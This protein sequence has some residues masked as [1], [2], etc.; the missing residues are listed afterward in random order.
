MTEGIM[1]LGEEIEARNL[2]RC[3]VKGIGAIL[4]GTSILG[5]AILGTHEY[6]EHAGDLAAAEA[7][8]RT[9][10]VQEENTRLGSVLFYT[11]WPGRQIGYWYAELRQ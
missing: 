9:I 7:H 3:A 1:D 10:L 6:R 11:T 5:G 8:S 4:L 2:Q